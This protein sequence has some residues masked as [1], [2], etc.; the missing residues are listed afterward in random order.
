MIYNS[1]LVGLVVHQFS[2]HRI[3]LRVFLVFELSSNKTIPCCNGECLSKSS[4][5]TKRDLDP[6]E[7]H[8]GVQDKGVSLSVHLSVTLHLKV[9][10]QQTFS[11]DSHLVEDGIPVV[12]LFKT[13]LGA[14]VTDFHA[15]K[16]SVRLRVSDR[17]HER[18]DTVALAVD[19]G[20]SEHTG[21]RA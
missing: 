5:R 16:D 20:V 4:N 14:N 2:L 12:F 1:E 19:D 21:M 18:V 17:D 15:W 10:R 3:S 9:S 8:D 6:C 11:G 13:K 7:H